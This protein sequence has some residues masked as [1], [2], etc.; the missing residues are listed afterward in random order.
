MRPREAGARFGLRR[1]IF[2]GRPHDANL[3]STGVPGAACT[4]GERRLLRLGSRSGTCRFPAV[5]ALSTRDGSGKPGMERDSDHRG[6]CDALDRRGISERSLG[7]R[8]CRSTWYGITPLVAAICSPYRSDTYR[9][10]GYTARP[11]SQAAPRRDPDANVRDRL[12]RW[13][14]QRATLQRCLSRDVSAFAF[15]VPRLLRLPWQ[16]H[17]SINFDAEVSVAEHVGSRDRPTDCISRSSRDHIS[18]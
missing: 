7:C 2:F 4:F 10:R 3:L 6:P 12:R 18:H 17:I 13:V 5:P 1:P 8:T 15:V 11:E 14:P 9:G 16:S